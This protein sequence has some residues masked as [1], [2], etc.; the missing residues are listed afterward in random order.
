MKGHRAT[1][2]G[3]LWKHTQVPITA[4][5]S[6]RLTAISGCLPGLVVHI[7]PN[8][9]TQ[10]LRS[11]RQREVFLQDF[12]W[13][14]TPGLFGSLKGTSSVVPDT[15]VWGRT[16]WPPRPLYDQ[17]DACVWLDSWLYHFLSPFS[18]S[19]NGDNDPGYL[20][21]IWSSSDQKCFRLQFF[22]CV[23]VPDTY[24]LARTTQQAGRG[25]CN[26]KLPVVKS[27]HISTRRPCDCSQ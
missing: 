13:D 9:Q 23:W 19:Q 4:G 14:S 3:C 21:L 20:A 11:F 1:C 6:P 22:V 27:I 15:G 18:E 8:P 2:H 16:A 7:P 17:N 5:A 25:T 26:K 12:P 24:G 10:T